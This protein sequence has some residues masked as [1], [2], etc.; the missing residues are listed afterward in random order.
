[1]DVVKKVTLCTSATTFAVSNF[2]F[3]VRIVH[4]STL[5]LPHAHQLFS[6]DRISSSL[7]KAFYG[8]DGATHNRKCFVM[9]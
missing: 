1:M 6:T 7:D 2:R 5:V 9:F 4:L 8:V 3:I